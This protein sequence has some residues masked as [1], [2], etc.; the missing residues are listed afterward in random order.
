MTHARRERCATDRWGRVTRRPSP[1]CTPSAAIISP[2]T[3]RIQA[4]GDLAAIGGYVTLTRRIVSVCW[5]STNTSQV[6]FVSPGTKLAPFEAK[7]M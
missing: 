3:S 5:S 4:A 7:T 6:S 2:H 1:S